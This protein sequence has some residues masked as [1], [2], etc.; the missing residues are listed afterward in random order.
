MGDKYQDRRVN[1]PRIW[2]MMVDVVVPV[3]NGA[4]RVVIN[5]VWWW[6]DRLRV[7]VYLGLLQKGALIEKG[8]NNVK[9]KA[10]T[11]SRG[12]KNK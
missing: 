6:L 8:V 12:D 4:L 2:Q 5:D 1:P 9:W 10:V 7:H 3:I 11:W